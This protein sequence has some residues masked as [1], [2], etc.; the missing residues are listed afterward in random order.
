MLLCWLLHHENVVATALLIVGILML[1]M[2]HLSPSPVPPPPIN[3]LREFDNAQNKNVSFPWF[4]TNLSREDRV[5]AL[6][7]EMTTDEKL[8]QLVTNAPRIPRLG[9]KAYHWRN[10]AIHGLSD[11]G[12]STQFPQAIGMAATFD[13]QLMRSVARVIADE[14]RA[15][16][17]V[18]TKNGTRDSEMN[19]GLDLWGPNI[20]MFRDPRWGRGQ[21]TYGE[22]PYLTGELAK[23]F[24]NGLQFGEDRKNRRGEVLYETLATC[25][26]FAAYNIEQKRLSFYA[27]VTET[28]LRQF[29]LPAWEGCVSEA[30]SVMCSFNGLG[31]TPMCMHPMLD[32]VLRAN[33]TNFGLNFAQRKENYIVSDT[34]AIEYMVTEFHKFKHVRDAAKA[35]FEAG[36]DLNSGLA[37]KKLNATDLSPGRLDEGVTRLFTA[38]MSLGLFDPPEVMPHYSVLNDRD[39]FSK[40]HQDVALQVSQKSLVMLKND[41]IGENAEGMLPLAAENISRV[42]VIGWGANDTY[43]PLG[44]YPG[45]GYD[46]WGPRIANC[47]IITPLKG[48]QDRFWDHVEVTYAHGCDVESLDESGFSEATEHAKEAD[49]VVFVGGN[50][51]CEHRQG[52]G[53]AHCESEGKDRPDLEL[54]GVQTKLLQQLYVV[55]P[56]I[57]FVVITGSAI[58]FPWEAENLPAIVVMWYGGQMGGRALAGA[59][60]GDFSPS[61]KSPITWY[62]GVKQLPDK[63]DMS[64]STPPGRTYRYLTERPLY[65]FGWGLTYG[66]LQ[67]S[68]IDTVGVPSSKDVA[69][70]VCFNVANIGTR[71]TE[72]VVQVYLK[73]NEFVR[74]QA[75]SPPRYMLAAFQR[76]PLLSPISGVVPKKE[77][78]RICLEVAKKTLRLMGKGGTVGA[79][80]II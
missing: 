55:N 19:Y 69:F 38:R 60:A 34:G 72:D 66:L 52:Q 74:S 18:R 32:N 21:E 16:H 3:N 78:I 20:N 45:C 41:V 59:L 15:K 35:A 1:I 61:G 54:P 13:P 25:K 26:H 9:V 58:S 5:S 79:R 70:K 39:V 31:E 44:N 2:N 57:V 49:V 47:S 11:N 28:D 30:V 80:L 7:N 43:A 76:T 24:V 77:P 75:L 37:Y 53:G 56:R 63:Y 4:D 51:N 68:D 14:Q 29:Y 65:P 33:E 48:I 62:T 17:N 71:A 10:N 12:L 64:P 67:F 73:P 50:R 40:P 27:K 23:A 22:D 6:V 46:P 8:Q 36:V 42:A